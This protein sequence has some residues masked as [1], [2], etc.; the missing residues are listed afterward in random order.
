MD[1]LHPFF[2][3]TGRFILTEAD[4]DGTGIPPACLHSWPNRLIIFM[5]S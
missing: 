3:L 5:S 2:A 1:S 4:L